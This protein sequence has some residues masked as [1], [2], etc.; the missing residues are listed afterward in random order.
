[1]C[2]SPTPTSALRR[3]AREYAQAI[4]A[5]LP[6]ARRPKP[7]KVSKEIYRSFNS[8]ITNRPNVRRDDCDGNCAPLST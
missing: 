8:A 4:S 6:P 7:K 1:M 3:L 2:D 5:C